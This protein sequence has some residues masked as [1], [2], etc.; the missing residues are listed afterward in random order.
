LN[1]APAKRQ[2]GQGA[3]PCQRDENARNLAKKSEY[4]AV[5][6]NLAEI[7]PRIGDGAPDSGHNPGNSQLKL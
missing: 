4:S 5:T 2:Y 3:Y 1:L 7:L 6:G